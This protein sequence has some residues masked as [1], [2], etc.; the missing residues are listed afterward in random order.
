[1]N[2]IAKKKNEHFLCRGSNLCQISI[3]VEWKPVRSS[4]KMESKLL[5]W[6]RW[7]DGRGHHS[8]DLLPQA[9]RPSHFMKGGGRSVLRKAGKSAGGSGKEVLTQAL[10][11]EWAGDKV[12]INKRVDGG[13][14]HSTP[15]FI[16]KAIRRRACSPVPCDARLFALGFV[17][18][19]YDFSEIAF[20]F[21]SWPCLVYTPL[22]FSSLIG[23]FRKVS[24]RH[25]ELIMEFLVWSGFLVWSEQAA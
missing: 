24:G 3:Y 5:S 8:V 19:S 16:F 14:W 10:L 21:Q 2:L 23:I 13:T 18:R 1:M 15:L 7:A 4:W 22:R 9:I 20:G 6:S 17:G 12:T 25:P 11:A